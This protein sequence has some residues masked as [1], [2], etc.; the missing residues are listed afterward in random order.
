MDMLLIITACRTL[1]AAGY[2][3]SIATVDGEAF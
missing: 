2:F 3:E 1:V